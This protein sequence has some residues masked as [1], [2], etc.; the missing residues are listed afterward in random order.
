MKICAE[1][2]KLKL[3][4]L[5]KKKQHLIYLSI[6]EKIEFRAEAGNHGTRMECY[7]F[8]VVLCD[9]QSLQITNNL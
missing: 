3:E 2:K 8:R 1:E 9:C 6:S 4:V 7:V 5:V